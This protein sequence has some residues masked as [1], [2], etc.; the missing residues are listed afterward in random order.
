M[1]RS[2]RSASATSSAR[3]R[4]GGTTSAVESSS[5]T[6]STSAGLPESWPTSARNWPGPSSVIGKRLP[7]P[8][9]W[10][11]WSLPVRIRCMPGAGSPMQNSVSP[12]LN[13][14]TVPNRRT[15]SISAGVRVGN[16]WC[17]RVSSTENGA[18]SPTTGSCAA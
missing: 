14:A 16:I 18:S 2:P 10:M 17:L 3:S 1:M 15:R 7:S 4:S 5:A 12:A 6:A 11:I 9:R 8:S 13:D